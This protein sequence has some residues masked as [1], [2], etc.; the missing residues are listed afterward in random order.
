MRIM[1]QPDRIQAGARGSGDVRA[2]AGQ[3][4]GQVTALPAALL[5][6]GYLGASVVV[7]DPDATWVQIGSILPPFAPMMMPM[8]V[9]VGGVPAAQMALALILTLG[10]AVAS[11]AIGARVY[12]GGI[13]RTGARTSLREALRTRGPAERRGAV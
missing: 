1:G 7:G 12:R 6:V 11:I 2:R 10:T 8:R 5:L 3:E 9:A 13:T 4:V